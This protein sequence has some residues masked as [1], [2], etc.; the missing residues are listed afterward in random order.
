[1]LSQRVARGYRLLEQEQQREANLCALSNGSGGLLA[2]HTDSQTRICAHH[3]HLGDNA[4][5]A[6]RAG[7]LPLA[8]AARAGEGNKYV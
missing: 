7:L 4:E 3:A 2:L 1:M 5:S 6:R 8:H